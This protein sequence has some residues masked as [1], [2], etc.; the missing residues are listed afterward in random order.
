MALSRYGGITGTE[1][2]SEDFENINDAFNNVAAENDE[3][4]SD[5]S[6]NEHNLDSHKNST[7]AHP[8]QHIPYSGAVVGANNTKEAL[9]K[10]KQEMS[11]LILGED[12]SDPN[13][14]AEVLAA[15]NGYD[16]LGDRLDTSDT[17]LEGKVS[18]GD[19]FINV[20]DYG[21][22]GSGLVDDTE[23]IKTAI[24]AITALG[25]GTIYFP[26]GR[27]LFSETLIFTKATIVRG[28]G[29][30]RSTFVCN[31]GFVSRYDSAIVFRY[32]TNHCDGISMYDM[33]V[34]V[35]LQPVH[36]ITAFSAYD[37]VVFQNIVV[38]GTDKTHSSFRFVPH[39]GLMDIDPVSQTMV[40]INCLGHVGE[41]D[42]TA[43][44]FY[45]ESVQ[46]T[47]LIGCKAFGQSDTIKT[48]STGFEFVSCRGIS[49]IGNSILGG[50]AAGAI[51]IYPIRITATYRYTGGFFIT[52]T[53][54]EGVSRLV[55]IKGLESDPT[56]DINFY[57]NRGEGS[58]G[59]DPSVYLEN[60]RNAT[61]DVLFGSAQQVNV[62]N[63]IVKN[64]QQMQ[65]S[66]E[67]FSIYSYG[68]KVM[69]ST[70]PFGAGSS[71]SISIN[72]G[73]NVSLKQILIGPP[74]SAGSGYRTLR[75]QN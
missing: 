3:I 17:R 36:G 61:V 9:D 72:D 8:A 30:F 45:F 29:S 52:G 62:S 64:P 21:A 44:I 70:Y 50:G 57:A 66:H 75:I 7:A 55:Y 11:D 4:K 63:S 22:V 58:G 24:D 32:D 23:A 59:G 20:K 73:T 1:K 49:M 39:E 15:R 48:L 71:M 41:N 43:P 14:R 53:T 74:D 33:R 28:D 31:S 67:E 54:F 42:A 51:D 35:G 27:Y 40:L 68:G 34:H 37:G 38:E 19:L 13:T 69:S 60:V 12:D 6:Q 16:T 46:E 65:Y 26:K 25:G 5:I 18:K 10:L 47:T 2:I 56:R